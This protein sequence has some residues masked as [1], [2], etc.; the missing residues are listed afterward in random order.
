MLVISVYAIRQ[1]HIAHSRTWRNNLR[2]RDRSTA[3]HAQ[4]LVKFAVSEGVDEEF[5][6][7]VQLCSDYCKGT[8]EFRLGFIAYSHPEP[9]W[10]VF[11]TLF[12]LLWMGIWWRGKR[13]PD[14]AL[15]R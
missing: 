15:P 12:R 8:I 5:D 4:M 3:H 11:S 6:A 1:S 14:L 13:L 2:L 9:L 7:V 10:R